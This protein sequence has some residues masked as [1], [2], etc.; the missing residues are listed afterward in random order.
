MQAWASRW[1]RES[2]RTNTRTLFRRRRFFPSMCSARLCFK[3]IESLVHS[4]VRLYVSYLVDT[5]HTLT[6]SM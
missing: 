6:R 1:A 3:C 4:P 5:G 2:S